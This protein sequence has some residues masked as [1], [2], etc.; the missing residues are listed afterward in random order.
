MSSIEKAL[1]MLRNLP[2]VTLSN[3]KDF[4]EFQKAR[5]R[6]VIILTEGSN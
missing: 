5:K 4:P 1:V 2:R 6:K 3:I